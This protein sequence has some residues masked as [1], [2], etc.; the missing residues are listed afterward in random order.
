MQTS[1]T[2]RGTYVGKF[3][4]DGYDCGLLVV[5]LAAVVW[6]VV[7]DRLYTRRISVSTQ[8]KEDQGGHTI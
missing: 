5:V 6:S 4:L 7:T 2:K 8:L 3:I 1:T